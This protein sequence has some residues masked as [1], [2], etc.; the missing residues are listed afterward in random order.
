MF[1]GEFGLP[2]GH[3]SP[4]ILGGGGG[5][6]HLSPGGGGGGGGGG[7]GGGHI[8]FYNGVGAVQK[9]RPR[10]RKIPMSDADG[11]PPLGKY[12]RLKPGVLSQELRITVI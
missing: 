5:G 4:G 12:L 9:G 1:Q 8:A 7:P 10:K 2:G 11:C 3:L 6:G